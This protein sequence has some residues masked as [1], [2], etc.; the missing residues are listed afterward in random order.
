MTASAVVPPVVYVPCQSASEDE[1]VVDLRT[2]DA[3]EVALLV[4]TALDRL[5]D[6]CGPNQ[7]WAALRT[8]TLA[9]VREATNFNVVMVDVVVPEHERRTGV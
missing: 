4:Y 7:P 2:T 1:L 6:C 5:V 9:K 8:E 3:G